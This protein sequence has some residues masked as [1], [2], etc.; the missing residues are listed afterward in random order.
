MWQ[1]WVEYRQ[2]KVT[3]LVSSLRQ[4][5]KNKKILLSTVIFPDPEESAIVK[6]QNWK[7][8]GNN[9]Y[10][11]AFTPLVMGSDEFLVENYIN[12][13]K[14]NIDSK[15][16]IY[17]GLFEPFT[18]ASPADMLHQIKTSRKAGGHGIVLFDYAHLTEEFV[19]SLNARAFSNK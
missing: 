12:D 8:W 18:S 5:A 14:E 17:S 6:L 19:K 11:D 1:K 9:F 10:V 16:L 2:D 13:I 15:I 7:D 3:S 4:I